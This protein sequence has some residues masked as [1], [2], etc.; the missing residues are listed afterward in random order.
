MWKES[1]DFTKRLLRLVEDTKRHEDAIKMIEL[2]IG[3]ITGTLDRL[4]HELRYLGEKQIGERE[5]MKLEVEN[6]LLRFEKALLA[7][8]KKRKDRIIA[9]KNQEEK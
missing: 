6:R 8:P 3:R 5:R 1:F 7:T 2:K 4:S 9:Y